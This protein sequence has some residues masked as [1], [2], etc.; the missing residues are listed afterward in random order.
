MSSPTHAGAQ[1]AP[2]RKE[3]QDLGFGTRLVADKVRLLNHDGS[4]NVERRGIPSYWAQNAYQVLINMNWPL[5]IL[6]VL[7]FYILVNTL[8]SFAY[9]AHGVDHLVGHDG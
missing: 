8:F 7:F 9:I 6:T 5:F 2:Q 4:F 3:F 1:R